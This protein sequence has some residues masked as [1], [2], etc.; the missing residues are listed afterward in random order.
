MKKSIFTA[1]AQLVAVIL[2]LGP[3]AIAC[4]AGVF[5]RS[6]MKIARPHGQ[7]ARAVV[8]A[9]TSS[10]VSMHVIGTITLKPAAERG[11]SGVPLADLVAYPQVQDLAR[12]ELLVINGGFSGAQTSRPVGALISS[13]NTLSLPNYSK[14][15]G[16]PVTSCPLERALGYRYS[17]LACA[18]GNGRIVFGNLSDMAIEQCRDA[19]Q[20]G[21]VLVERHGT[22][23]VCPNTEDSPVYVRSALCMSD[24]TLYAVITL[25][26]VTL[27][28]LAA[29]LASP[30]AKG[31]IGCLNAI[32]LG[33][34]SSAGILYFPRGPKSEMMFGSGDFPQATVIAFAAK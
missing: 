33:G 17:A 9:F 13:G 23:G 18:D 7:V 15:R 19:V 21:P 1:T 28:D 20:A 27:H 2:A 5:T 3:S 14:T 12:H 29:W 25:D 34:Y 30:V 6:D 16:D 31:G 11:A 24:T 26:P 32:N 4:A 22:V 8:F 10:Q